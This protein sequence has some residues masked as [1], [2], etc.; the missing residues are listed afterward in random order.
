MTV[1][2][3]KHFGQ[4]FLRDESIAN[5]IV[6]ALSPLET[7]TVVEVG[8]GMGVLTKYLLELPQIE[9]YAVELDAESVTYLNINYPRLR[10]RV[11]NEDFLSINLPERFMSPISIIG[12]FPYNISSQ[13]LFKVLEY[14]EDVPIM[15]G[16]FQKEVADRVV[17]RPGSKIYG[18][19]SVL[20]QAFYTTEYLFTVEA[21]AFYP[22][23]KVRSAVIRLRRNSVSRLECD[24]KAFIRTVKLAF[25][26]RRKTLRNALSSV[27][28]KEVIDPIFDQRAEQLSVNDFIRVTN[29]LAK[30]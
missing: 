27:G 11:I 1:R 5:K 18:I 30:E 2:P 4:H 17:A 8:P 22:P 10:G 21:G 14:R 13:I 28:S 25:N 6:N 23:P 24:E 19:L 3:K 12:N 9:I 7:T 29:L 26:Q 15:V 20:I 16:M